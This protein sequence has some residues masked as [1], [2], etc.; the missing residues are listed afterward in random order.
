MKSPGL[1]SLKTPDLRAMNTLLPAPE[2][3][4]VDAEETIDV[5]RLDDL[6]PSLPVLG[7]AQRALL[8]TDTQGFDL[9]VIRGAHAFLARTVA[10]QIELSV[11]PI[12]ADAPTY[13]YVIDELHGLGFD[14]SGLFPVTLDADLRVIELDGIFVRRPVVAGANP[15]SMTNAD[16]RRPATI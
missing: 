4:G 11:L 10:I 8:K 7:Q 1:S 13:Q 14:L 5:R 12:Y 2:F 16:P 6:V 9:E 15:V 3:G